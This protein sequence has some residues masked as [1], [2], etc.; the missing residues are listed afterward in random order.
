MKSSQEIM[1]V[2]DRCTEEFAATWPARAQRLA[3]ELAQAANTA[4]MRG[5]GR[6]TS[7]LHEYE[8]VCE[9]ALSDA[10]SLWLARAT[11]VLVAKKPKPT[12]H[13]TDALAGR[14]I[15]EL[16]RVADGLDG[17]LASRAQ[18]MGL[19]VHTPTVAGTRGL[20][21]ATT[22]TEIANVVHQYAATRDDARRPW[23]Q[24]PMGYVV[25]TVVATVIGGLAVAWLL[26]K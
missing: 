13:L 21:R 18:T 19:G 24:R 17:Q 2:V 6:S 22:A 8:R 9:E 4:G 1:G 23:Y 10:R 11:L 12:D 3:G 5:M 16:E 25:L 15:T 14:C 26:S 20:L 7:L